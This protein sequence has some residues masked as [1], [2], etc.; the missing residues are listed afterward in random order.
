M[1]ILPELIQH[2]PFRASRNLRNWLSRL[3]SAIGIE[4]RNWTHETLYN[5]WET[6]ALFSFSTVLRV[7]ST[8]LATQQETYERPLRQYMPEMRLSRNEMK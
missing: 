7:V 1:R 5:G 3:A 8:R 4:F 2:K 6:S